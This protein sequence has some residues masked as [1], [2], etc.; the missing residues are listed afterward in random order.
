MK[1]ARRF[2]A[3]VMAAL[4]ILNG[5][6]TQVLAEVAENYGIGFVPQG[7]NPALYAQKTEPD[8][9][10]DQEEIIYVETEESQ[11]SENETESSVDNEPDD[12]QQPFTADGMD[13]FGL[14]GV[15][16][17]TYDFVLLC[18][19][20]STAGKGALVT[21]GGEMNFSIQT[22]RTVTDIVY[23]YMPWTED[24]PNPE[25]SWEIF[26][27]N[28]CSLASGKYF[29]SFNLTDHTAQGTYEYFDEDGG[30]IL[31]VNKYTL[32][33]PAAA[34]WNSTVATWSNSSSNEND[35]SEYE[36]QLYFGDGEAIAT[37]SVPMV[38]GLEEYFYDFGASIQN[39]GLYHYTVRAI[40]DDPNRCIDS[41]LK[42]STKY[43]LAKIRVKKG[44]EEGIISV[45]PEEL[46]LGNDEEEI[47]RAQIEEDYIFT[48]WTCS[49]SE[50]SVFLRPLN[51]ETEVQLAPGLE[52]TSDIDITANV[53]KLNAIDG[54]TG[55]YDAAQHALTAGYTGSKGNYE[56]SWA[57]YKEGTSEAVALGDTL[58]VKNVADSGTYRAEITLTKVGSVPVR[59]SVDNIVVNI[60]KTE[61][62]VKAKDVSAQYSDTP[63]YSAEYYIGDTAVEV[64]D[65]E[66]KSGSVA[67]N[68]SYNEGDPAGSYTVT[69]DPSG[70]VSD[71]YTYKTHG[72]AGAL[73]VTRKKLYAKDFTATIADKT[74]DAKVD[75]T[76]SALT[77]DIAE[78]DKT[79]MSEILCSAS[80]VNKNAGTGK[81]VTV[82]LSLDTSTGKDYL[83][84]R[85]QLEN[86]Q[87]EST[88][89]INKA[90]ITVTADEGQ[91][92]KYGASDPTLTYTV[93]SGKMVGTETLGGALSRE[94]GNDV[95]EYDITQGTLGDDNYNITF[96][97][98]KFV[99]EKSISNN[100]SITDTK[101]KTYDKQAPETPAYTTN[102]DYTGTVRFD[103]YTKS[104]EVYTP[105]SPSNAG[106][107]Y[108]RATAE[109]DSNYETAYSDYKLL[110]ISPIEVTVTPHSGQ[111]KAYAD[112]D[113]VITYDVAPALLD[114]DSFTGGLGR[115]SGMSVGKYDITIGSLSNPNYH[116]T[117]MPEKFEIRKSTVPTPTVAVATTSTYY[118]GSKINIDVSAQPEGAAEPEIHYSTWNQTEGK[119]T[120]DTRVQP[121][122]VG[123]Y[124]VW[125]VV[126]ANAGFEEARSDRT[127]PV[128]YTVRKRPV[129]VTSGTSNWSYD[130]KNHSNQTFTCEFTG[131]DEYA[132]FPETEGI[133]YI[134]LDTVVKDHTPSP[135]D[136]DFDVN[137]IH[138]KEGTKSSNYELTLVK[139]KLSVTVATLA[140]AKDLEWSGNVAGRA[141]WTAIPNPV[142]GATIVYTVKLK[143]SGA[144]V[145]TETTTNTYFDFT[146]IIRANVDYNESAKT[147]SGWFTFSVNA[148]IQGDESVVSSGETSCADRIYPVV[149]VFEL[150]RGI[151]VSVNGTSITSTDQYYKFLSGEIITVYSQIAVGHT[152]SKKT[153]NE[154][155]QE[156]VFSFADAT[157]ASTTLTVANVT[158]PT[159]GNIYVASD[160]DKP[161]I[162]EFEGENVSGLQ[163]VK[164]NIR[165]QNNI[166][167]LQ[168]WVISTESDA[169]RIAAGDWQTVTSA[170]EHELKTQKIIAIGE[171]LQDTPYY[172]HVKDEFGETVSCNEPIHVYRI[173]FANG[174]PEATGTMPSCIKV[175]G[176]EAALPK[177]Q[178]QK[179]A[180]AFQNWDDGTGKSYNDE[181]IYK[182]N[183][184]ALLTAQWAD[185]KF[186]YKVRYFFADLNGVY[187]EDTD[188][189]KNL[190]GGWGTVV[191]YDDANLQLGIEGFELTTK[192]GE[193]TSIE[194][195]SE[196][197]V[198]NVYYKRQILHI[199]YTV[200]GGVA[201]VTYSDAFKYGESLSG[202]IRDRLDTSVGGD[203]EGYAFVG[204]TWQ[205]GDGAP[206][207]MPAQDLNVSGQLI[208]QDTTYLVKVYRQTKAGN[209]EYL[210]MD[211]LPGKTG[212]EI[213]VN[214]SLYLYGVNGTYY[215]YIVSE[216]GADGPTEEEQVEAQITTTTGKAHVS[217]KSAAKTIVSLY[218]KLNAYDITLVVY[219][220]NAEEGEGPVYTHTFPDI[221]T[222]E[223]LDPAYYETYESEKWLEGYDKYRISDIVSWNCGRV[224][225]MP[226]QPVKITR[227]IT[228][229]D[230][231]VP[232]VVETYFMSA[233]GTYPANP[234]YT[235]TFYAKAEQTTSGIPATRVK[236]ATVSTMPKASDTCYLNINSA[237]V[238]RLYGV[239]PSYYEW[240]VDYPEAKSEII[241]GAGDGFTDHLKIYYGN[242]TVRAT[243][244]Y[245][246]DKADGTNYHLFKTEEVE[247]L[248]GT[249]WLKP[250]YATQYFDGT[251]SST[252]GVGYDFRNNNY[253][254]YYSYSS[255]WSYSRHTLVDTSAKITE[256]NDHSKE[257]TSY[258]SARFGLNGLSVNIYYEKVPEK[259]YYPVEMYYQSY[260]TYE[261]DADP[262]RL[263][264]EA[265]DHN[266]YNVSYADYAYVYETTYASG[267][268]ATYPGLNGLNGGFT[269]GSMR[270][271]FSTVN[272][273]G[274]PYAVKDGELFVLAGDSSSRPRFYKGSYP[275][276]TY[277]DSA[278][279]MTMLHNKVST[280]RSEHGEGGS[281]TYTEYA[282]FANI[283]NTS[284][285]YDKID[286]K[287]SATITLRFTGFDHF[288]H[289]IDGIP[290]PGHLYAEGTQVS[291]E[292]TIT[293]SKKDFSK[294]AYV[295]K[296]YYDTL[297]TN[298]ITEGSSTGTH[299]DT[300]YLYGKYVYAIK[301]G[302]DTAYYYVPGVG[303]IK[304]KAQLTLKSTQGQQIK[305]RDGGGDPVSKVVT[306][307]TYVYE[308]SDGYEYLA[309]TERTHPSVAFSDTTLDWDSADSTPVQFR[310]TDFN[311]SGYYF[312]NTN[313]ENV[314]A[315]IPLAEPVSLVKHYYPNSYVL[316][317]DAVSDT[318]GDIVKKKAYKSYT[319]VV[320]VDAPSKVGYA[321]NGWTVTKTSDG[322]AVD[323]PVTVDDQ[324][325]QASF[326]MPNYNVTMK[327]EWVP[328]PFSQKI[329]Y[330]YQ[331][332]DLI[333][334]DDPAVGNKIEQTVI[335][336]SEATWHVSDNPRPATLSQ[337][338][339][340]D[341]VT[342]TYAEDGEN[343]K[344]LTEEGS[345]EVKVGMT[346][347][348]YYKRKDKVITVGLKHEGYIE[349]YGKPNLYGD[350]KFHYGRQITVTVGYNDI[351]YTFDGWYLATDSDA[352]PVSTASA[353]TFRAGTA[354]WWPVGEDEQDLI[355]VFTP[356][357]P[358]V[359]VVT[360]SGR[361]DYTFGYEDSAENVVI[362]TFDYGKTTN[363]YISAYQ[364]Y[365]KVG[366]GQF[367]PMEGETS[368]TLHYPLNMNAGTYTYR[369][370]ATSKLE[371]NG[372]TVTVTSDELTVTVNKVNM[373]VKSNGYTGVYDAEEHGPVITVEYPYSS[374]LYTV[375]YSTD[376]GAVK[377]YSEVCP[378]FT[379]VGDTTVYWYIR[380]NGTTPNYNDYGTATAPKTAEISITKALVSVVATSSTITKLYDHGTDVVYPA[381][382]SINDFLFVDGVLA[383]DELEVTATGSSYN[384]K[385]VNDANTVTYTGL[386]LSGTK[387]GNYTLGTQNRISAAGKI[388]PY[389]IT[390]S[391]A[392]DTA[393]QATEELITYDYDGLP[394]V[395]VLLFPGE[396]SQSTASVSGEQI[397]AGEYQAEATILS[398][399]YNGTADDVS[400]YTFANL[401]RE[402]RILRNASM[403][404]AVKGFNGTYDG[405]DHS[406]QV[407]VTNPSRAAD[408]TVYYSTTAELN[409]QNYATDGTTENPVFRN[410]EMDGTAVKQH[411]VWYY[412]KDN[413]GNF[414]DCAG[415]SC[416]NIS[417]LELTAS[418]ILGVDKLFDNNRNAALNYTELVLTGI[419]PGEDVKLDEDYVSGQ[420]ADKNVGRWTVTISYN[421][422]SS[423]GRR[424]FRTKPTKTGEY[425]HT[426]NYVLALY[427]NQTETEA[428]ITNASF[429]VTIPD[430]NA[431]FYQKKD[432][433]YTPVPSYGTT[434]PSTAVN[435]SY[436]MDAGA[437]KTYAAALPKLQKAGTHTVYF[438]AE[439]A[440]YGTFTGSFRVTIDQA[441]LSAKWTGNTS[442]I[443]DGYS[444]GITAGLDGVC[445]GDTVTPTVTGVTS[446][447]NVGS[448]QASITGIGGADSSNYTVIYDGTNVPLDCDWSISVKNATASFVA[449]VSSVVYKGSKYTPKPAVADPD[450]T[451]G[452]LE[453]GTDFDYVYPETGNTEVTDDA[454]V[455]VQFKGNYTGT[456][457]KYFTITQKPLTVKWTDP[458]SLVY[459]AQAKTVTYGLVGVVNSDDVQP[460][461]KAGSVVTATNSNAVPYRA[462]VSQLAGTKAYNYSLTT[463]A[464]EWTIT[465]KPLTVTWE[466]RYH[467]PITT[468]SYDYIA[469]THWVYPII[470]G[471]EGDD[472]PKITNTAEQT[473]EYKAGSYT[474]RVPSIKAEIP[475][476][477][478]YLNYEL[479]ANQLIWEIRK[480][481]IDVVNV[482]A[483]SK[484]YD[485]TA[486]ASIY[487]GPEAGSAKLSGVYENDKANVNLV[488]IG[489][490]TAA[491]ADANV[492]TDKPVTISGY[493]IDGTAAGNYE[494]NPTVVTASIAKDGL[495]VYNIPVNDKA[496]DGNTT[497]TIGDM[498]KVTI[499]G[500]H[501]NDDVKVAK[502]GVTAAFAGKDVKV[503]ETVSFTGT[504]T[505]TGAMKDNYQ[506]VSI[507]SASSA[508]IYQRTVTITWPASNKA[509]YDGTLKQM[510]ATI[511]NVV[512]GETISLVE[513]GYQET[514]GGSYTAAVT[515]MTDDGVSKVSNYKLPSNTTFAWTIEPAQLAV[516]A[517]TWNKVGGV[518]GYVVFDEVQGIGAVEVEE[519]VLQLMKKNGSV[520]TEV[521]KATL[522]S[523]THATDAFRDYIHAN[524]GSYKVRLQALASLTDNEGH[525]NVIDS[526]TK[527]SAV[528]HSVKVKYAYASD[529]ITEQAIDGVAS[530]KIGSEIPDTASSSMV[531]VEDETAVGTEAILRNTT[532][533]NAVIG[534]VSGVTAT[535]PVITAYGTTAKT[536][537]DLSISG[538][539]DEQ[540][541][542][543]ITVYLSFTAHPA[544]VDYSIKAMIDSMEFK[545]T[546][547]LIFGYKKAPELSLVYTDASGDHVEYDISDYQWFFRDKNKGAVLK[548]TVATASFPLGMTA[549]NGYTWYCGYTATRKDNGQSVT[550]DWKLN[551]RKF[552]VERAP[553]SG[554]NVRIAEHTE[555]NEWFYGSQPEE[556]EISIS[557]NPDNTTVHYYYEATPSAVPGV[558]AGWNEMLHVKDFPLEVGVYQFKAH[559]DES[560]NYAAYDTTNLCRLTVKKAK[561]QTPS[562]IR[563]EIGAG[564]TPAA[565]PTMTAKWDTVPEIGDVTV[566]YNLT[567]RKGTKTGPGEVMAS[568]TG[569]TETEKDIFDVIKD[570]DGE[571]C[572]E[573]KAISDL[574]R[575]CDDSD[576]GIGEF[577]KTT[578][579]LQT[580]AHTDETEWTY[581]GQATVLAVKDASPNTEKYQWYFNGTAI[582]GATQ[583]TWNVKDVLK[584]G[585]YCCEVSDNSGNNRKISNFIQLTISRVG[586]DILDLGA[587]DKIYDRTTSVTVTG[588]ARIYPLY[589]DSS[590][591]YVKD[592]Q[593]TA[594]FIDRHVGIGKTV[595]YSGYAIDGEEIDNY[596]LKAQPASVTATISQ[597]DT[598]ITGLSATDK[599]YDGNDVATPSGTA[600]VSA[601]ID[602]DDVTVVA[603]EQHFSDKNADTGKTVTFTGYVLTGSDA[604]NYH[605][606]AQPA[607]VTADITKKKITVKGIKAKDKVYDGNAD[608]TEQDSLTVELEGNIDGANVQLVHGSISFND[609]TANSSKPMTATGYSL[610]GTESGNYELSAQP[611]V[612]NAAISRKVATMSGLGAED[613]VYD[614]TTTAKPTGSATLYGIL[615]G[616]QV[617]LDTGHANF[618]DKN[619][620]T[621]KTVTFT[622]YKLSGTDGGNYELTQHAS[623]TATI[624]QLDTLITGLSATDKVYDGND[625]ATPSGTAKVSARIGTDDVT[626]AAGEQHFSD[627]NVGTDKNVTFTGYVLTG[628]DAHN[629]H[630]TAQ[631]ASVTADIT[632]KKVKIVG[633]KAKD[634]E[635]DGTKTAEADNSEA[636]ID[637]LLPGDT[638]T[639]IPGTAE[640]DIV[641]PKA[642][643]PVHFSGYAIQGDTNN[644][645]L[646]GQPADATATVGPKN[647]VNHH[648]ANLYETEYVFE[649]Q[650]PLVCTVGQVTDAKAKSYP[651]FKTK[652]PIGQKMVVADVN[653]VVDIYY[654]REHYKVTFAATPSG[655]ILSFTEKEVVF[656]Q[657]FGEGDRIGLPT[658]EKTGYTFHGWYTEET[659]GEQIL[660]ETRV[661]TDSERTLYPHFTPNSYKIRFN[662]NGETA[663]TMEDQDMVYD[664][665]AAL[666]KNG[667]VRK[668][669][670][671]RGWATA[672]V[673]SG[674]DYA[675]EETVINLTAEADGVYDLYAYW[676]INSYNV[677]F[678]L[679][680]GS[681]EKP[682]DQ[683]VVFGQKVEKP[684]D[685][686]RNGYRFTGWQYG[687]RTWN[688]DT[689]VVEQGMTLKA[690]WRSTSNN[691]PTIGGPG[692]VGIANMYPS[693]IG[694]PVTTYGDWELIDPARRVWMLNVG[695]GKY[696]SGG[697]AYVKNPYTKN[698]NDYAWFFF[699]ENGIMQFGW[700]RTLNPYAWYYANSISDTDLGMLVKGW[701]TD[702]Q[703]GNVYYLD[704]IDGK[705]HTGW[706][707]VNGKQYYFETVGIQENT[708]WYQDI[709]DPRTGLKGWFYRE[710]EGKPLGSMYRNEMTPDGHFVGEDG[711]KVR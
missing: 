253:V 62:S 248:W 585:W 484:T 229:I 224:T 295:A 119:F 342:V 273:G 292:K 553:L 293:C 636:V 133:E 40:A 413:T 693:P 286:G 60:T 278:P 29:L 16:A 691:E 251:G 38:P 541:E 18:N 191:S 564:A 619:V 453:E 632:K 399:D 626:A 87:V 92:K 505:L 587:A 169:S 304:N 204:W 297:L 88:G 458:A 149:G 12:G 382:L 624:S 478:T 17:E 90:A 370:E 68:T 21:Y 635:Y 598:L 198:L 80:F 354:S 11:E 531:L 93:T 178:Y 500:I 173:E 318:T 226:S 552:N 502:T 416:V 651:G 243:I 159:V 692:T 98:K 561:L 463:S 239:D 600:K 186:S 134:V 63:A 412:I 19:G 244:N 241:R 240:D 374:S 364:W 268:D 694:N 670:T 408:V 237:E 2:I 349:G 648:K 124:E 118:T 618:S 156:G 622:G 627:K 180:F 387:S 235:Q 423:Y 401:T 602:T 698:G 393:S 247:G 438:K 138:F 470:S 402:F 350:G 339:E 4:M 378:K 609:K 522:D 141:I 482:N 468:V 33:A 623:V 131:S 136:N 582:S 592:D 225:T 74:Y 544:A 175:Q 137:D 580:V 147:T 688:F 661:A 456:V 594:S 288:Y 617:T 571:Y 271:G 172:L 388:T 270:A 556:A 183:S 81:K 230:T 291:W 569:L 483:D 219:R 629:Y 710:V 506:I 633:V 711:V 417:Q 673:A 117:L 389:P 340:F 104:G 674:S 447:T 599:V 433:A 77:A 285:S 487:Y 550:I 8:N 256:M 299:S 86:S 381:G 161:A 441:H 46:D 641:G 283:Y 465:K 85:Y 89:N 603:G 662:G 495:Y 312:S 338:F 39:K 323:F 101:S 671:F 450:R 263:T 36:L 197:K 37:A 166:N 529:T 112:P 353:F 57:W 650:E 73:T 527:D 139:G 360:L 512:S 82:N 14:S 509:T 645:E 282:P 254:I 265:D 535:T 491:F 396:F 357:Q 167:K 222:N 672:S 595:T 67:Y 686:V 328:A 84:K 530:I 422:A 47:I 221:S 705:M 551:Y 185:A 687:G 281:K 368:A 59:A 277:P 702:T 681:G 493:S 643:I 352:T 432:L 365:Q 274:T 589:D 236:L 105:A 100:V 232:Y 227:F 572:I 143:K 223:S 518:N 628:S 501:G 649:E 130:G 613:K 132:A 327:A 577:P 620:G 210:N 154:T 667:Y 231:D 663:G 182:A 91:S 586:V 426:D 314:L 395:P 709:I 461:L 436:S 410:V 562:N 427:G 122:D 479:P 52:N 660:P 316:Y 320:T 523:A 525:K 310:G 425:S 596:Y 99:I 494:L 696:A 597:L 26:D 379:D 61:L 208:G 356:I 621:G 689:D 644:Y 238:K 540:A 27:S 565:T 284:F 25:W 218:Y 678:D 676:T 454:W 534:P 329:T 289:L 144:E 476:D 41:A 250:Y 475:G 684:Q 376:A 201:P 532:G 116:V 400:N 322:T 341:T 65:P 298:P 386:G 343:V 591:L 121:T 1:K 605:L 375:M 418:G 372:C 526:K 361:T 145:V 206:S 477:T 184:D 7:T 548:S 255:T 127:V 533:Y 220:S 308:G 164:L 125:V 498:S 20:K 216:N 472:A 275:S 160:D 685:P 49:P 10:P 464:H 344:N 366:N 257:T 666:K 190:E 362:S 290:C 189:E 51:N 568:Y 429:T 703:D 146:D 639:I 390:N 638:L 174:D 305:V 113:P 421:T 301:D 6:G 303:Y 359:P 384:K 614:R 474:A 507:P 578:K 538:V 179:E 332:E 181:G 97:S 480:A 321:F 612:P 162:R 72:T 44:L 34:G 262:V 313:S 96:V 682:Q 542:T 437:Q 521:Q 607:S 397:N 503:K 317:W 492:G 656:E 462:T 3:L 163:S 42:T 404:V 267:S 165:V 31:N 424:I 280:Y 23:K 102:A 287:R 428:S 330:H 264:I 659:G 269:Y 171:V 326:H 488:G 448:Y 380:A 679:N 615:D 108:V 215:G 707:T 646:D 489:S 71:N 435:Y 697:W 195:K 570:Y 188:R 109:A 5:S 547:F 30:W 202:K 406:I 107:Y 373:R 259:E 504:F 245:Y 120:G 430:I 560:E 115:V 496:Y 58:N 446:K 581:D 111:G 466:D 336:T 431:G 140:Y 640:F 616:D 583:H 394:H 155:K 369:V 70:L 511:S 351:G 345:A 554:V 367:L 196:G 469:L 355:A 151:S 411:E 449:D 337:Y 234:S 13:S 701:Y 50:A 260:L 631:P 558:P 574:P 576:T 497:A 528:L 346:I 152:R 420:F 601:R 647:R 460:V 567:V 296:W 524:P 563:V 334:D 451:P 192:E 319:S 205:G 126:P 324:T 467:N 157:Q 177:N 675:N 272:V 391:W 358:D 193:A 486:S 637:G 217:G 555:E 214:S 537:A 249:T 142:E 419:V 78:A 680:G 200:S 392:K 294:G 110:T 69:A 517:P 439:A 187:V 485:G 683:M 377:Q 398:V 307:S 652:L 383:D 625:V 54:Y 233:D 55:S 266:T 536:T 573:V 276:F 700:I 203:Y 566:T 83:S 150:G 445:S 499:V 579:I 246:Y 66:I 440:N 665:P 409:A 434:T 258:W 443:Y 575:N 513:T 658:A 199:N 252:P 442:Y 335:L 9:L 228:P 559:L 405:M 211:T 704:P 590:E 452:T 669:Y 302:T 606:T 311:V 699:D 347:D 546:D 129:T 414:V 261:E 168:S 194:L 634:K 306:S 135:V 170:Q 471:F 22:S 207:T 153:W 455:D 473:V 514:E 642:D 56:V 103:Y 539:S 15:G 630:L 176:K 653:T 654:D 123:T 371:A 444:H 385:D 95:G 481:K 24:G 35:I 53:M 32:D 28:I 584:S 212:E 549:S 457:R 545:T 706:T 209:Y 657:T 664:V 315:G 363:S 695:N 515:G 76:V 557:K 520:Y 242:K 213:T 604:H 309:L 690:G 415:K 331:N 519:Y 459:N 490:E 508:S 407:E 610:E 106:T 516:T 75:A 114:G 668:G 333:Y 128:T 158:A 325:K 608:A 64:T 588:T 94:P 45:T 655:V 510:P 543:G 148:S 677:S 403:S 300:F 611:A 708:A 48:G 79:K 43:N 348:Y 279:G 593:A